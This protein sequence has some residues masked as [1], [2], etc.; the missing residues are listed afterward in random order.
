MKIFG[1]MLLTDLALALRD[2]PQY[3]YLQYAF[4]ITGNPN[5]PKDILL[6]ASCR[7]DGLVYATEYMLSLPMDTHANAHCA[8]RRIRRK[9]GMHF[10]PCHHLVTNAAATQQH[11]R[12]AMVED[13]FGHELPEFVAAA[14][15]LHAERNGNAVL[16][17]TAPADINAPLVRYNAKPDPA[18][19]PLLAADARSRVA[20]HL[21]EIRQSLPASAAASDGAA[22]PEWAL[23][24]KRGREFPFGAP[25]KSSP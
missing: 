16:D 20:A 15:R 1:N 9:V 3:M 11:M 23:P 17:Y 19:P 2:S 13:F 25:C 5:L 22:A 14:T 8:V 4:D 21:Q 7:I 10:T 24:S 6:T 18:R 12:K